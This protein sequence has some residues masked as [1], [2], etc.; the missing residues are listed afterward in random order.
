MSI[1]VECPC[2]GRFRAEDRYAGKRA[3]CPRCQRIL[4][5]PDPAA[6][7]LPASVGGATPE[8]PFWDEL[9]GPVI[10]AEAVNEPQPTYAL[11]RHELAPE[12]RSLVLGNEYVASNPG[13]LQVNY[14][15]YWLAFPR[16][17]TLWAFGLAASL[18][19]AISVHYV[20]SAAVIF[21]VVANIIYWLHVHE[22]F[23]HGCTCPA[24]LLS[25]DDGL[26][27]VFDDL[28]MHGGFYPCIKILRQPVH[29]MTG[30][31]YE[32]D[33]LLAAI[34][35]YRGSPEKE[36]HWRQIY[37]KV[38][39]CVTF[40][41]AKIAQVMNSIEPDEWALLDRAL[42]QVPTPYRPGLYPV[43]GEH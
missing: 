6:K 4:T 7:S 8:D 25:P 28:G 9:S 33:S 12:D 31:P 5:V 14:L 39:H 17:P 26:V 21:F 19:F 35:V 40:S 29:W 34:A 27:A 20:W 42:M 43:N 30:G 3:R 2:G 13:R 38:V 1:S 32:A 16:W 15:K 36:R 11:R 24:I 37:P 41:R 23:R 22:H 10:A 18:V